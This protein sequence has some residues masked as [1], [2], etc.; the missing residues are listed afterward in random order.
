MRNTRGFDCIQS[1]RRP[2]IAIETADALFRAQQ[3]ILKSPFSRADH[4]LSRGRPGLPKG[5]T[6]SMQRSPKRND[7]NVRHH[8]AI[9]ML[10]NMAVINEI[11]GRGEWNSDHNG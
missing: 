8:A 7:A 11:A 9:L 6:Q 1:H 4:C 10:A 3:K 5:R 2:S